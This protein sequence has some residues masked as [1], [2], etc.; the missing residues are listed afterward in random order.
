MVS[1]RPGSGPVGEA[2]GRVVLPGNSRSRTHLPSRGPRRRPDSNTEWIDPGLELSSD[3]GTR[4]QRGRLSTPLAIVGVVP[5][6][7]LVTSHFMSRLGGLGPPTRR[8]GR[9]G[10]G[11]TCRRGWT[12]A[13]EGNEGSRRA[14]RPTPGGRGGGGGGPKVRPSAA[15]PRKGAS[16]DT[17]LTSD[18]IPVCTG[19]R[20]GGKQGPRAVGKDEAGRPTPDTRA[21]V[22]RGLGVEVRRGPRCRGPQ[23]RRDPL[24]LRGSSSMPTPGPV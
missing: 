16:D 3:N 14:G 7:C 4:S 11:R 24:K 12:E 22:G 19:R 20:A 13:S 21:D 6:G 15:S 8:V 9:R 23:D 10:L 5:P 1:R 18:T 2:L 17:T